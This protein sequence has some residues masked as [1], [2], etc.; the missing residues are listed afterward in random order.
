MDDAYK[1][2]KKK[3]KKKKKFYKELMSFTIITAGLLVFNMWSS[4]GRY[5]IQWVVGFW[6]IGLV[7]QGFSLF[8]N[9]KSDEWEQNELRKEL[10]AQGKNPDDY[11]EDSLE[12]D[13]LEHEY[14]EKSKKYK[15]DDFV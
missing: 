15:D 14:A 13:D 9:D 2:A 8:I 5:W 4:P 3:V 6:A 10:R 7:F 1:R 12:L 11:I